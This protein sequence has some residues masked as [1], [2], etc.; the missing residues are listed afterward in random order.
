MQQVTLKTQLHIS[1]NICYLCLVIT[2]LQQF[3]NCK[4]CIWII[5]C[6][7]MCVCVSGVWGS[8]AP[9]LSLG[10]LAPKV[11]QPIWPEH[12]VKLWNNRQTEKEKREEPRRDGVIYGVT[13]Q[14]CHVFVFLFG[15]CSY[16][17]EIEL[18]HIDSIKAPAESWT[19]DTVMWYGI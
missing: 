11:W 2:G 3:N 7:I 18:H 15:I 8:T 19:G 17:S 13:D 6:I 10:A 4:L 16:W 5:I 9:Q 1:R 12:K 14:R